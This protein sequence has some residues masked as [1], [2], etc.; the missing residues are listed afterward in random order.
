M[1]SALGGV[2]VIQCFRIWVVLCAGV[3]GVVLGA[4]G[5]GAGFGCF[6]CRCGLVANGVF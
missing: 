2:G 4:F 3:W 5:V 6:W 1:F